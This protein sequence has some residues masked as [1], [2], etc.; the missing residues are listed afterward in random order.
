MSDFQDDIFSLLDE[1]ILPEQKEPPETTIYRGAKKEDSDILLGKEGGV[2][3][4][5]M[6]IQE[7]APISQVLPDAED[8]PSM[9]S[10][11]ALEELSS[12]AEGLPAAFL[13]QAA[14]HLHKTQSIVDFAATVCIAVAEGKIKTAQSSEMRKWAELMYSCIIANEPQ[15]AGVQVN[16][17]EQLIQLAGGEQQL[18]PETL[19]ITDITPGKRPRKKAQGE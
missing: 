19:D 5:E 18:Q 8:S 6:I 3:R 14:P 15:Q 7:Q 16:Y 17:V 2:E 4:G 1:P 9:L 13:K 11:E 12:A 10:R